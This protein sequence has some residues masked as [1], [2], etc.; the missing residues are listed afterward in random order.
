MSGNVEQVHA[1]RGGVARFVL[2][3]AVAPSITSFVVGELAFATLTHGLYEGADLVFGS[4]LRTPAEDELWRH[5]TRASE[6]R[7]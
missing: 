6:R 1:S 7:V 2:L 5:V 4:Y 3:V